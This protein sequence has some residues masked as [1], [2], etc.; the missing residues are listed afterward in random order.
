[1]ENEWLRVLATLP[2]QK[3]FH[4]QREM[5]PWNAA[6]FSS[7]RDDTAVLREFDTQIGLRELLERSLLC[8]PVGKDGPPGVDCSKTLGL[9]LWKHASDVSRTNDVVGRE[10]DH[11]FHDIAEFP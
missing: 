1:M 9:P 4:E 7:L 6:I 11:P 2:S 5:L 8:F 3:S 10:H